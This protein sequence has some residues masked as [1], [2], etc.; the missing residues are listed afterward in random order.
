M[1]RLGMLGVVADAKFLVIVDH[2][3]VG[4]DRR[5][6]QDDMRM[7]GGRHLGHG[8]HLGDLDMEDAGRAAGTTWTVASASDADGRAPRSAFSDE[9]YVTL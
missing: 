4:D 6:H 2:E 5:R 8:G 7:R 9:Q 3:N 1:V